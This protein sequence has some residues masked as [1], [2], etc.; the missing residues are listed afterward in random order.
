MKT[1]ALAISAINTAASV[2]PTTV[3]TPP[4]ILTPPTTAA[5]ITVSSRLGGT[6]DWITLSW[7]ANNRAARSRARPRG[8]ARPGKEPTQE[9]GRGPRRH[10]DADGHRQDAEQ[11]DIGEVK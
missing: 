8:G 3:P 6:V 2:E 9:R 4:R 1:S 11:F 7:A 10:H 5:V